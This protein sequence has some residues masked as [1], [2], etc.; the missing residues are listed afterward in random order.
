MSYL[1]DAC[2][3]TCWQGV[4]GELVSYRGRGMARAFLQLLPQLG[5]LRAEWREKWLTTY[6]F[7]KGRGYSLSPQGPLMLHAFTG[8]MNS[9]CWRVEGVYVWLSKRKRSWLMSCYSDDILR[10]LPPSGA[11]HCPTTLSACVH[12]HF[13]FPGSLLP[14]NLESLKLK[15]KKKIIAVLWILE[16]FGVCDRKW[17]FLAYNSGRQQGWPF[18]GLIQ[19]KAIFC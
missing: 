6:S 19:S 11:L 3:M 12:P 9:N 7:L 18:G 15:K 13:S 1:S 14:R 8:R 5:H 4:V 2:C 16:S 10:Y 17:P